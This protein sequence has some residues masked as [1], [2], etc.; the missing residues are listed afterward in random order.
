MVARRIV[1]AGMVAFTMLLAAPICAL[2]APAFSVPAPDPYQR[3]VLKI[4]EHAWQIYSNLRSTQPPFEGN[5][6]V[7]EQSADLVVVDAGGSTPSGRNVVAAI[8]AL[9]RKQVSI[10]RT[11]TTTAITTWVPARSCGPGLA[12]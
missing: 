9:S 10:W 6:V 8:R 2:A 11:R 3:H 12:S 4:T 5:V 7:F 1:L